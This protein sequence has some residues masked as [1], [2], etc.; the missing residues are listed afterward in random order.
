MHD[1]RETMH[2]LYQFLDRELS[3][4]DRTVVEEH[5]SHCPPCRD[6][7]RFEA[8]VLTYIGETCRKTSAP[9]ELRE[10]VR[11]LCQEVD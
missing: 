3:D 4:N 5:L 8:N 6:L 1:C 7:F 11:K 10:R 2:R 9:P